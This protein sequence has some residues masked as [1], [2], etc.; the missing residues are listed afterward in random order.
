[1]KKFL[2]LLLIIIL[3]SGCYSKEDKK[4]AKQ[5]KEQGKINALAYIKSKYGFDAKVKNVKNEI[6]CNN[7]WK[8]INSNPTGNVI[9][10]MNANNKDFKVY[11]TGTKE[12]TEATDDYQLEEIK[13]GFIDFFKSN[14]N[15]ELYD[16]KI[17]LNAESVKELYNNNLNDMSKYIDNIEL[18]YIGNNL[19][20]INT[21]NINNFLQTSNG[22]INLINF[23]D[24]DTCDNYKKVNFDKEEFLIIYKE[25]ELILKRNQRNFYRYDRITTLNN[26]VY[27]YSPTTNNRFEI[28]ESTLDD[29][30]N[31]K[32]LY[33][34]LNYK[35]ITQL[36]NAYAINRPREI[37]YLYFPKNNIK[38]NYKDKFFIASE[39]NVKGVKKH[40]INSYF[41][42]HTDIRINDIGFYYTEEENFSICDANSKVTFALIKVSY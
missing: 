12:S 4:L 36:S 3:L 13:N 16:Y 15:L 10:K 29:I 17:K 28:T 38:K 42:D 27:V 8:C 20:I 41:N 25:S 22:T 24:K 31:Y 39:C 23:K 5:Y 32:K 1:M 14:I 6:D 7:S 2:I 11:T 37:L 26:E 34:D 9:V 35:K 19:E 40:F 33:E 30:K 21:N 18:Y